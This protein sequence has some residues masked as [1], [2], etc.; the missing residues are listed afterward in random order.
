MSETVLEKVPTS[1]DFK[2]SEV[3][4]KLQLQEEFIEAQ[5]QF[6]DDKSYFKSFESCEILGKEVLVKVFKFVPSKEL[7]EKKTF[8]TTP[9]MVKSKL[10]GDL[11]TTTQALYE[12]FYPIVK[13]IKKGDSPELNNI[14]E[15]KLYIVPTD[16]IVGDDWNPD[17]L[18]YMNTFA[19]A[20]NGKQGIVHTP[21]E[22]HQKI[23][24]I[25]INWSR[26]KFNNPMSVE[27]DNDCYFIIPYIKLKTQY[28][29]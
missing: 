19:K 5:K 24:K 16:D 3:L 26:Y 22:M 15:G 7:G 29:I 10:N 17:F 21:E 12:R 6:R 20:A 25:E 23:P 11:I 9:L 4:F 1:E 28:K 8:G 13:V 18:H 14:E 2:N 27:V